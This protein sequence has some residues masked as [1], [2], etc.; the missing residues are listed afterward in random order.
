[1][2]IVTLVHRPQQLQPRQLSRTS[3]QSE[4]TMHACTHFYQIIKSINLASKTIMRK[5]VID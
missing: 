3:G 2:S 1:M 4:F 5:V